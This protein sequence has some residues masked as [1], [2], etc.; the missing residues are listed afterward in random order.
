MSDAWKPTNCGSGGRSNVVILLPTK[1]RR[2][3][4]AWFV[5]AVGFT[6]TTW[7]FAP[8]ET[9]L[10]LDRRPTSSELF[11]TAKTASPRSR[12][13]RRRKPRLGLLTFDLDDTLFPTQAVV[14]H[15]NNRMVEYM[16]QQ[17]Y[18]TTADDFLKT[19][20][21]LRK[22]IEADGNSISYTELRKRAI[23]ME[24][25]RIT[26]NPYRDYSDIVEETYAT[27]EHERHAAAEY[28]LSPTVVD[29]LQDIR[30]HFGESLCIAAVTNGKGN[31]VM[32]PSLRQF[33]SFCVSGE[34]EEVFPHR[35]PHPKIF[36]TAMRRFRTQ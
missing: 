21:T 19:T 4:L 23:D 15:A 28:Y 1:R 25:Q 11:A 14:Q 2:V 16:V 34:D 5:V 7:A 33:F 36:E 12:R 6:S 10:K 24:L 31:P 17:G 9:S 26:K 22:Q 3:L 13:E 29:V 8:P 27:W 20:R 30:R 32:M 18:A 35:K